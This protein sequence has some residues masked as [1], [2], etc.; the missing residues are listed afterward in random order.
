MVQPSQ[1]ILRSLNLFLQTQSSTLPSSLVSRLSIA[2]RSFSNPPAIPWTA[3]HPIL[4]DVQ[5]ALP[6]LEHKNQ[7]GELLKIAEEEMRGV[8]Q[9]EK[10]AAKGGGIEMK[11][12]GL[13]PSSSPSSPSTQQ[14][15]SSSP[16]PTS[17]SIPPS[18]LP[19]ILTALSTDQNPKASL[20][21]ATLLT[22]LALEPTLILPPGKTLAS[23]LSAPDAEAREKKRKRLS[24]TSSEGSAGRGGG[25]TRGGVASLEE[26][27]GGMMKQAF[28]DDVSARG[29]VVPVWD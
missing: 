5:N 12:N 29:S 18:L 22:T 28:W 1:S 20:S 14:A 10:A 21:N 25:P 7:F 9:A 23:L 8:E 2:L 4:I 16:P 17:L 13:M 3:L 19:L 24:A 27:V 15:S 11:P 6:T 26:R